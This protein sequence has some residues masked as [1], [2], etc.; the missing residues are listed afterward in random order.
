MGF[1]S[2]FNSTPPEMR[3]VL[4]QQKAKLLSHTHTHTP[5]GRLGGVNDSDMAE[6][7][8]AVSKTWVFCSVIICSSF[9]A[10]IKKNTSYDPSLFPLIGSR[11]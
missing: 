11:G 6:A 3:S 8:C 2:S 4:Q 1:S 10:T 7:K 5:S 9:N